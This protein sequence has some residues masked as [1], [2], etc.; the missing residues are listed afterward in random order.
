[1]RCRQTSKAL[2]ALIL[3]A[4]GWVAPSL[5]A[6]TQESVLA[7][8]MFGTWQCRPVVAHFCANF[9]VA[10]AGRSR[11]PARPFAIHINADGVH[12]VP[13]G[14]ASDGDLSLASIR[15]G[16]TNSVLVNFAPAGY[17]KLESSGRFVQ[18]FY[19]FQA[20]L[21]VVESRP[22]AALPAGQQH[23]SGRGLRLR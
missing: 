14:A 7:A 3:V 19:Q 16:S 4:V 5:H 10:C 20:A 12:L 23:R 8:N 17:L 11:V 15:T 18:R 6:A 9:H 21:P 22:Q 2:R 1:M 13:A